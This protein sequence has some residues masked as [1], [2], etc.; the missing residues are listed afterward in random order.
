MREISPIEKK[1]GYEFNDGAL[2]VRAFTHGSAESAPEK[3]YQSLEFLGDSILSFVIAKRLTELYPKANE[4]L[5]TKMRA[6]IVSEQPLADAVTALGISEYLITGEGEKKMNVAS[7]DSVKSDIFEAV[8]A[9]IYL[10]GGFEAA[11]KFVLSAL[12]GEI[13]AA[14]AETKTSDA[15]SLLN[16]YAM[17]RGMSVEYKETERDGEPHCPVFAYTAVVDGAPCGRGRG[18]SK[19]EAQQQAAAAALVALKSHRNRKQL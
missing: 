13:A 3:N 5:L 6:C 16:E 18:N 14:K 15:K 1:I 9:A 10:D 17:K 19:R 12:D 2:L 7:H 8:T 11:E 4:G